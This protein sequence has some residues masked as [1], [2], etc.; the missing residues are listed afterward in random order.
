MK[1]R[2]APFIYPKFIVAYKGVLVNNRATKR[3]TAGRPYDGDIC[4]RRGELCS[5]VSL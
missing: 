4:Y 2:F 3:A 5:P 1:Q